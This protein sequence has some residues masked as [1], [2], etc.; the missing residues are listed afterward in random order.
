MIGTDAG[1]MRDRCEGVSVPTF[2]QVG[3]LKCPY[4]TEGQINMGVTR[5]SVDC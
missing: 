2:V 3:E 4:G 5:V 1:Q